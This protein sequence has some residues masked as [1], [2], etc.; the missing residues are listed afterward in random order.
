MKKMLLTLGL[1][2]ASVFTL[3]GCSNYDADV[4]TSTRYS[5]VSII[6]SKQGTQTIDGIR[7]SIGGIQISITA[8]SKNAEIYTMVVP[9]GSEAPTNKQLEAQTDYGNV[10]VLFNNSGE[11]GF[12]YKFITSG[13]TPGE[14]YD[15]YAVIK[16][17]GNYSEIQYKTTVFT[18][19]DTELMYKGDGSLKDPYEVYTVEDLEAVGVV[20]SERSN[21]LEAYYE[22]KNNIDLSEKYNEDGESWNPIGQ[23]NGKRNKFAGTFNGA[24]FTISGL[25]QN[26]DIEGTGL[27]SELD[28]AGWITNLIL[29][30]VNIYTTTQRTAAVV[31][32]CKGNVFNVAVIGGSITTTANRCGSITGHMYDNGIINSTYADVT[33]TSSA[34]NA[35]GIVGQASSVSGSYKFEIKNSQF[36]GEVT[37]NGGNAGGIV[38]SAEDTTVE[39]CIVANAT[40]TASGRGAGIAGS[41]KAKNR[42][43]QSAANNIVYN[44]VVYGKS[45]SGVLYSDGS[46]TGAVY[47]NNQYLSV[48]TTSGTLN[49]S[50]CTSKTLDV[51]FDRTNLQT[52]L[53]YSTTTYEFRTNN[54]PMLKLAYNH[55]TGGDD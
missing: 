35:G 45:G 50:Q 23:V 20:T 21:A 2:A 10:N 5:N 43:A 19:A 22:L 38:G 55:T 40:V 36:V 39:N 24:G 46:S 3:T 48:S 31:G 1:L 29:T 6:E 9:H 41:L 34:A 12:L 44:T 53:Y 52:V 26:T 17:G 7:Y 13:Y 15:C 47:S 37:A 11:N 32:Y 16:N 30:N 28:V 33:I 18:Y 8:Y 14:K 42:D 49:T 27:F 51:L 4:E 25:Y 54:F